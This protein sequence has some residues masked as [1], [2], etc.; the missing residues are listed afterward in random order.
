[1]TAPD[2]TDP[3]R[4]LKLLDAQLRHL[5]LTAEAAIAV[6]NAHPEHSATMH[7][8]IGSLGNT[9]V[10]MAEIRPSLAAVAGLPAGDRNAPAPRGQVLLDDLAQTGDLADD[11][12]HAGPAAVS[13]WAGRYDDFPQPL[14]D[15]SAGPVYSREQV[16]RWARLRWPGRHWPWMGPWRPDRVHRAYRA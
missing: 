16:R 4:L 8:L 13:T 10:L 11:F 6:I 15:L 9:H 1:M 14:V 12:G 3:A 7:R 5:D 2:R